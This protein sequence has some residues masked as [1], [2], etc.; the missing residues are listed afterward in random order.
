MSTQ[1]E[2]DPRPAGQQSDV[3]AHTHRAR[4]GRRRA[5]VGC[6]LA[7]VVSGVGWLVTRPE[8]GDWAPGLGPTGAS[9]RASVPAIGA[10]PAEPQTEAQ[11]FTADRYF[12]A[13]R[14]IDLYDFKAK[15]T[16]TKQ[17]PD[18]AETLRDRAHDVLHGAG[19]QGYV[20]VG[21]SGLDQPVVTTVT[22]LRF[23]D[24]AAAAK[25]GQALDGDHEAL[26]FLVAPP[27]PGSPASAPLPTGK[28]LTSS[29]VEAVGHYVTVTVS[30]YADL[31]AAN[32][33][34]D[35]ALD[36]ATRAVS[37]TAGAPFAWM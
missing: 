11:S 7:V 8:P 27:A 34:P 37:F 10:A 28:P 32:P 20:S 19:C 25:A 12:P 16:L 9:T 5:L 1:G 4:R 14:G 31:R 35:G 29:R 17:G 30:R 24:A 33:T 6:T 2:R 26:A 18:C 23:A 22:V 13:Q 3:P 21:F 36:A 15:R